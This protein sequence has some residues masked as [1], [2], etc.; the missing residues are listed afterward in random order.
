MRY[1]YVMINTRVSMYTLFNN[2]YGYIYVV[3]VV[4]D[5]DDDDADDDVT[6]VNYVIVHGEMAH[7]SCTN[8]SNTR[9]VGGWVGCGDGSGVA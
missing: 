6:R 1:I 7:D 9:K 3:D 5:D 2:T 8:I 4:D